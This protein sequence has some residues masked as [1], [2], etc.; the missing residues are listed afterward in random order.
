VLTPCRYCGELHDSK[1]PHCFKCEEGGG[2]NQH[3]LS[4]AVPLFGMLFALAA[5][6]AVAGF[7]FVSR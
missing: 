4:K 5:V 3:L 6:V 2:G 7:V 1:L